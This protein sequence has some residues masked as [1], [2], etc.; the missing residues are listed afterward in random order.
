MKAKT[1]IVKKTSAMEA[2][3]YLDEFSIKMDKFVEKRKDYAYTAS[4]ESVDDLFQVVV[5]VI[6][7]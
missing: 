2:W 3:D 5:K 6:Q 4:V 1:Y 7:E